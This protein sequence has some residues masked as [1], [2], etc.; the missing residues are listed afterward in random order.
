MTEYRCDFPCDDDCEA[1]CH[2]AHLPQHKRRQDMCGCAA[3]ADLRRVYAEA[4]ASTN[5]LDEIDLEHTL[6]LVLAARDDELE[7]VRTA[8]DLAEELRKKG[9]AKVR[10][11]TEEN[12]RLRVERDSARESR[13]E[14]HVWTNTDW[15]ER[16]EQA[17]RSR[18]GWR[19]TVGRVVILAKGMRM[20]CSPQGIA[21][22]YADRIAEAV[23][24]SRRQLAR[25][26]AFQVLDELMNADPP[27][28]RWDHTKR[29]DAIIAR[30]RV[31]H[32]EHEGRCVRCVQWCDC[33]DEAA[34]NDPELR[35]LEDLGLRWTECPHGNEPYPCPTIRALEGDGS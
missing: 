19:E 30:V 32:A 18:D 6:G 35:D 4:L 20:W 23:I 8:F 26:E 15:K 21:P 11:L 16:A 27:P 33:M 22:D 17:E 24:G 25:G 5:T 1:D 14:T 29:A 9:Q 28:G 13:D 10:E 7:R 3:R 31:L 2:Q 12:A 34:A